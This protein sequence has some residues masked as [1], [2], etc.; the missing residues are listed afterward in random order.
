V[1]EA[2]RLS[3][4]PVHLRGLRGPARCT[5]VR[6]LQDLIV[7]ADK[8]LRFAADVGDCEVLDLDAGHMCMI[9]QPEALAAILDPLSEVG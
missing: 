3:S 9:S 4:D 7:P 1:P 6:T 5:W 8:Q 2:P